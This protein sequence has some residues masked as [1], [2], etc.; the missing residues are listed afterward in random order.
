MT[1]GTRHIPLPVRTTVALAAVIALLAFAPRLGAQ[2][3]G[4]NRSVEP[5]ALVDVPTAGML[6]GGMSSFQADFFHSDGLNA[7]FAYGLLDRLMIGLSYGASHLI[8][9]EAPDWNEVPGLMLRFRVVEE[10]GSFPAI[11]IGFESQ[12]AEGYVDDL[13]RF[14]IK[15]P[16][17]YI[18]GSK[19]FDASGFLGFHGGVNYSFE[20]GDNDK[21][22]NFYGGID[23]SLGSFMTLAGEYNFALNDNSGEALGRGRG[24]LNAGVSFFPGAGIII[25]FHFKDLLEN[26]PHEGFANRTIRFEMAR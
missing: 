2:G 19:N 10:S 9:T 11:A 1:D 25:S 18:A 15:S 16:G 20:H 6:R 12:G 17:V 14:T 21:D 8:G 13:D 24:Y 23:K 3:T 22:I 5:R 7:A 4:A 26:Q